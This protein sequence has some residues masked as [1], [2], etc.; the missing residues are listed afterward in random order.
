[1]R[2]NFDKPMKLEV[3]DGVAEA[4]GP[5]KW[6]GETEASV[7][8]T[9]TQDDLEGTA[10]GSFDPS[11]DNEEWMLEVSPSE[12]HKKFKKGPARGRAELKTIP[13]AAASDED[14]FR[15]QDDF[16]LDPKAPDD[17]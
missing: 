13:A 4:C 3:N 8:V 16:N 5:L 12:P 11:K 2:S 14:P 10:S 9:I 17:T 1:M 15:W 6:T 7:T